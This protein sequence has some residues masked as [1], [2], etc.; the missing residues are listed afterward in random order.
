MFMALFMFKRDK[1]KLSLMSASFSTDDESSAIG[2]FKKR[3]C[4]DIINKQ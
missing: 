4:M 1:M 3:M 2:L